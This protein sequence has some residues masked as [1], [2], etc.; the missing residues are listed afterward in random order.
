MAFALSTRM[1]STGDQDLSGAAAETQRLKTTMNCV[2][3]WA[4]I[5]SACGHPPVQPIV[6]VVDDDAA[7]RESLQ[8][9]AARAGWRAEAFATAGSFLDRP[10]EPVPSCLVLDVSLP[11]AD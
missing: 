4:R 7:V 2:Q 8:L 6:Y 3:H 11:H 1:R 10:P 9:L 5:A